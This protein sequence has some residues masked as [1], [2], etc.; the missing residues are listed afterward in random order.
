MRYYA[1]T[2]HFSY[3]SINGYPASIGGGGEGGGEWS[4]FI[5]VQKGD[6]IRIHDYWDG[7]MIYWIGI[8]K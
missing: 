6:V 4:G 8:K 3:V 1:P 7:P 2:E 5:P